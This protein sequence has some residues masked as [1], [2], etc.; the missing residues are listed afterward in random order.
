[1]NLS[2]KALEF[3]LMN[4]LLGPMNTTP[5]LFMLEERSQGIQIHSLFWHSEQVGMQA[6]VI[7]LVMWS[8]A[9]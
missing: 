4:G 2:R 6:C 1:M 3:I 7:A 5:Q 9:S 8:V